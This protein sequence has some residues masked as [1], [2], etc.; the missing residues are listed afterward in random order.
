[1]ILQVHQITFRLPIFYSIQV[2]M[3]CKRGM[4]NKVLL[5]QQRGRFVKRLGFAP[6]IIITFI[7][8]LF[9]G[10]EPSINQATS[11]KNIYV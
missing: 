1:M 5:G 3:Q 2:K 11:G 8:L 7:Y 6:S 9:N 10:A 4:H